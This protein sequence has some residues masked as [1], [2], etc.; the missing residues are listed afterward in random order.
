MGSDVTSIVLIAVVG[1][2]GLFM[3][4]AIQS[5]QFNLF[6]QQQAFAFG[7]DPL[8]HPNIE[9]DEDRARWCSSGTNK[10][11][12]QSQMCGDWIEGIS[13]KEPNSVLRAARQNFINEAN[14]NAKSKKCKKKNIKLIEQDPIITK[15]SSTPRTTPSSCTYLTK[16]ICEQANKGK[17]CVV[18][19]GGTAR[20]SCLCVPRSNFVKVYS[21]SPDL[22]NIP[23][24]RV[25]RRRS[26][27]DIK[28]VYE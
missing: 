28:L 6:P 24:V 10:D 16:T 19:G 2:G 5:G 18:R 8:I 20:C 15:S 14:N 17:S 25:A 11:C 3:F 23:R 4:Q 13:T 12:E 9:V 1:I 21:H 7:G 27:R 22:F 26:A